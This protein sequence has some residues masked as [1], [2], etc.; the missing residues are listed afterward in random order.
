MDSGKQI[1]GLNGVNRRVVIGAAA[2][3][4]GA[5]AGTDRA[6]AAP[7]A[8][9]G[10]FWP[11]GA[12]LAIALS[13]VVETGA[14]PAPNTKAPDGKTYPDLYAAS[15]ALYASNEGIPRI[16]DMF[17]RRHM[18]ATAMICGVSCE[19]YPALVK[20]IAQRG[21]ECGAH[22]HQ[23]DVQYNMERDAERAF[24]QKARDTI[25]K[26]TGQKPLGYNC[27]GQLRSVNTLSL[28]QELGFT[29]HIDD[30]SRDEP[31][32]IPVNDKPFAVVPYTTHL[33]D[34]G[35]FNRGG[36]AAPFVEELKFEFDALYAEAETRRRMMVVTIHDAISRASRIKAF[37][38]FINY[39]QRHK[40]VWFARS[41]DLAQ[42]A[43]ESKESIRQPSAI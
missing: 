38:E 39:A 14:D 9:H 16:L 7:A 32:V 20:D 28:A 37:E 10:S 5:L 8:A 36:F 23:H 40:G 21:H 12:R 3:G 41:G 34:I 19:K 26:T 30:I 11:N 31:F 17:D 2:L 35:Y 43:L 13:L 25:E 4:A 27:R 33:N 42:W 22:G 18:K 29:Y 6:R 15:A 24:M 1:S